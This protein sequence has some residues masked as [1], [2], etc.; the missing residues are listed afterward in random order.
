MEEFGILG[1]ALKCYKQ[2]SVDY[3]DGSCLENQETE[4]IQAVLARLLRFHRNKDSIGKYT[5]GHSVYILAKNPCLVYSR[6]Q[7]PESLNDVEFKIM[8]QC[9]QWGEI[10]RQGSNQAMEW[11]LLTILIQVYRREDEV[12]TENVKKTV[13]C[14]KKLQFVAVHESLKVAAKK[15]VEKKVTIVKEKFVLYR[16]E[17]KDAVKVGP[18]T[19]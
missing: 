6:N 7:S 9:V 3:F 11:L 16:P 18:L 14:W 4:G 12:G 8:D 1:Q 17:R 19:H 5:R 10:V 13:V 2:R 15:H